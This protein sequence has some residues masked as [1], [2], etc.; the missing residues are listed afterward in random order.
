MARRRGTRSIAAGVAA[1]WLAGAGL[2]VPGTAAADDGAVFQRTATYPVY[3]NND[4]DPSAETVAEISTVSGDGNTLIYTDALARQIGFLDITDPHAPTGLGT[5]ALT[6]LGDA[7]DEPTSVAV[8]GDYVLVVIN[9]SASFTTPSG[10]LDVIKLADRT[11][12]RSIELP[13]QPDSIAIAP[14]GRT[15]A[16]AIENERDEEAGDG[17]LPQQPAGLISFLRLAPTG[18]ARWTLKNVEIANQLAGIEG[19]DTPEDPEPEYVAYSPDSSTVALTLQENNAIALFNPLR[20]T[21]IKAF[22][23]GTVTLTGI[24]TEDDDQ[25]DPTGT[26]TDLPR[27]PDAIGW[28]DDHHVATANE[29]DWKGGSRGWTIFDTVTG[30]PA[31]DAGNS[32]E[33]LAISNGLYPEH[34]SADKG[35]EPEG[36][37]IA[38]INGTRYGFVA[39]ERANFVAVYDLT[40]PVAPVYRQ[41]LPTTNGPEGILPIPD[42]HLLAVSSETDEPANRVRASV[43]LFQLGQGKPEFPTIHSVGEQPIPWG[44]LGALSRDVNAAHRLYSVTDAAYQPTRILGID[45]SVT[46]AVIDTERVITKDGKPYAVDAEGIAQRPDGGFWIAAEGETGPENALIRLD[47]AGAVRQEIKLP[48]E[49]AAK[50][51]SQGLEGV[52]AVTVAGVEQVYVALQ[53]HL[54]GDPDD[55]ARIGR[56]VPSTGQWEWFGY[57]LERTTAE[58]DWIGLSEITVIDDHRLALIERDKLNGPDAAIKRITMITVPAATRDG[59]LTPLTKETAVD[60]LPLLRA[61]NG[62]TQEKLEGLTIAGD[63]TVYAITDNDGVNDATGETIFL[64]LGSSEAIFCASPAPS[65]TPAPSGSPSPTPSRPTPNAPTPTPTETPSPGGPST[66]PP[67]DNP[68]ALPSDGPSHPSAPIGNPPGDGGQLPETGAPVPPIVPVAAAVL[69]GVGLALTA[70]RRSTRLRPAPTGPDRS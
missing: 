9:T 5:L 60:V 58:G 11:R 43:S 27:E 47:A 12:V 17:G 4:D 2:S 32:F 15:A 13:G 64:R 41:T 57:P 66:P 67:S 6:E 50:I 46:P 52:A 33:H 39:A 63:G 34:R 65:P 21:L 53:R 38:E 26:L 49:L 18:P 7:E 42:R 14:D 35:S 19:I 61:T 40:D 69:I 55:T 59:T 22:S 16:I 29:G 20:G 44:A 45:A 30:Q 10:R 24:D 62:W 51:K 3:L 25:I 54:D 28:V 1:L 36:L 37:A 23:A 68:T 31:W 8:V 70:A 56:F 48:D